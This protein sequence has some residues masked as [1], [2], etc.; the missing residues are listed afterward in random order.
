MFMNLNLI[1]RPNELKPQCNLTQIQ[2]KLYNHFEILSKRTIFNVG[3]ID[4]SEHSNN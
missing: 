1:L 4:G 3:L 2:K